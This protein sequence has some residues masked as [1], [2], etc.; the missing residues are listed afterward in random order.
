VQY[1]H[2]VHDTNLSGNRVLGLADRI[3]TLA[4]HADCRAWPEA[5]AEVRQAIGSVLYTLAISLGVAGSGS[6]GRRLLATSLL[7]GGVRP[8]SLVRAADYPIRVFRR[9]RRAG[10]VPTSSKEMQRAAATQT[11]AMRLYGRRW[12]EFGLG[13]PGPSESN[14]LPSEDRRAA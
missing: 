5:A 1:L 3:E 14:G 11:I 2:R 13:N 8:R 9:K 7:V 10:R 6:I 12:W 4:K